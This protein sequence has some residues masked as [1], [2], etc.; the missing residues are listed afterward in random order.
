MNGSSGEE[1][2]SKTDNPLI[3][4]IVPVYKTEQ[5][6]RRCVDSI[7]RQS[8]SKLE[9]ILV[10]DGSPDNC[11]VICDDYA[12][13]DPR[14][15]VCHKENGGIADA[16]NRGIGLATGEYVTY[17][18]SDDYVS[19][20]YVE[21]LYRLLVTTEADI[22]CCD[23]MKAFSS[24]GIFSQSDE[25]ILYTGSKACLKM[26][27]R[28]MALIVPWGKIFSLE[29]VRRHP[30]PKGKHHED[31]FTVYR[32]YYDANRVAVGSAKLYAYFQNENGFLSTALKKGFPDIYEAFYE[33]SAFFEMQ[34]EKGLAKA[35]WRG[36]RMQLILENRWHEN[37]SLEEYKELVRRTL[38]SPYFTVWEKAYDICYLYFPRLF[39]LKKKLNDAFRREKE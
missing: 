1:K 28:D 34:G 15:T 13:A 12:A 20:D 22:A 35:S 33:R 8:Y 2:M 23:F 5:Y 24:D 25:K 30:F 39:L 27:E 11:G 26:I 3:S 36:H 21:Y 6:L 16:R 17:I 38:F 32:Y 19:T 29:L 37:R 31:E 7:I 14:I 4:V 10:D 18:D 9:I